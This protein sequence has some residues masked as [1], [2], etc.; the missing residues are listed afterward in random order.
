MNGEGRD[1][2]RKQE[3]K[4]GLSMAQAVFCGG[5]AFLPSGGHLMCHTPG[6]QSPG[7]PQEVPVALT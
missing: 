6:L 1:S 4:P 2:S 5:Q 7:S 3:Q